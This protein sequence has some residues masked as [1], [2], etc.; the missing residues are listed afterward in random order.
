M[1][2]PTLI[3]S[4][5]LSG[6][7]YSASAVGILTGPIVNPANGHSYFLLESSSWPDAQA[8]A[9]QMGGN[10]ATIRSAAENQ[11]VYDAFAA[12]GGVQ[13]FLWI[14]LNDRAQEGTFVWASG[15]NAPYR[16]W[17]NSQPDAWSSAEDCVQ[18]F[19]ANA[20]HGPGSPAR[21]PGTW[22]DIDGSTGNPYPDD[23]WG[24]VFGPDYGVV[25][26]VP[27]PGTAGLVALGAALLVCRKRK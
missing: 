13:R 14:G 22:N 1:K 8:Q 5:L 24:N 25:E 20:P 3:V 23:T 7:T 19:P 2:T 12:Y 15:E 26:I 4:L 6:L 21:P 18:M 27:E 10:L 16:N 11:W 17:L 9:V